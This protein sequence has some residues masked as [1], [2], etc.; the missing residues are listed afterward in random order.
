MAVEVHEVILRLLY[1]V[2]RR[3]HLDYILAEAQILSNLP[4]EMHHIA[5]ELSLKPKNPTP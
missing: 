5:P 3:N 1:E 2:D 4:K